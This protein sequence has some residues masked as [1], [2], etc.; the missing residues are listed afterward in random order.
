MYLESEQIEASNRQLVAELQA[1]QA[2]I[3]EALASRVAAERDAHVLRAALAV[4]AGDCIDPGTKLR[5][6]NDELTELAIEIDDKQAAN[7]EKQAA[8]DRKLMEIAELEADVNKQRWM[9][10][11]PSADEEVQL[12]ATTGDDHQPK[13]PHSGVWV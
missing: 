13:P 1:I 11:A 7:A 4:I 3:D 10:A 2:D 12:P 8:F 9:I 5:L 6:I